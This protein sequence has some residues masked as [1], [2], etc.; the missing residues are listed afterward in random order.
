MR[1]SR[2][3]RRMLVLC[4]YPYGVAAAQ[5]LKFEQYYDDWR[6]AGWEVEV[7]PFMDLALWRVLF[8]RGHI[9]L[10]AAGVLKGYLRRIR[11]L[12]RM[13]RYHLVYVHMYVTPLGT[14]L[15]ERVTRAL[16]KKLVYDV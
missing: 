11:D 14:S 10:K 15:A 13:R 1:R 2:T 8:E 4:P 9:G 6:A 7:S 16:T 5:R 12:F 3:P